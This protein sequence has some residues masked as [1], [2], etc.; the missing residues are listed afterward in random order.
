MPV[1]ELSTEIRAPIER[2]F[3]LSR[4]VDLHVAST[5]YTGE[6]AVAGVTS[7]VMSLGQQVTWRAR[8]FGVWH[9]LTS[10]ITVFDR[11]VHFRDSLVRG[12][13][14]RFDHDHFFAAAD[15]GTIMRDVFDYQSPLGLLGRIA[16]TLFLTRYMT[17]LLAIRNG[18]IKQV[19]ESN[20][21]PRYIH[22]A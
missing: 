12:I 17:D 19:A 22:Q 15:G 8:H 11:P 3:D 5:A 21:W 18:V 6:R 2:V 16:D 7:G 13:F 10:R 20:E 1:I 4:S 14:R 9:H